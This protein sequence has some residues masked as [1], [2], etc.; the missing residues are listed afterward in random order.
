MRI[1]RL[2]SKLQLAISDAQSLAVGMDHPAIE[3]VHLLQALLEQQGGSIKPLLMQVGFD[4]NSLRQALVKE[5]DQLPKIQNPTGDVNMSQD[6]ARLLNQADRLAQQKGDQFISSELVL[7]AAMD[8][9]SKLGK[10]LLSQGVSKKA[11]ENA[12]NNLRGGA[13]VNDANAEE[14]RQALDK[15]TVDLTKR[16]EEGK[17][18]PVIGRDDEIRRTVQVLQRRTKNNPVLIGEPGVGKTAIAEGLAQRIINGEVPDG[19][20]GKRLLA[21]DMGA[22]IAGAKYRGEFEERLKGLLN[23]LSKQEGQIILFIDELHTMVGAGKG[24][25]AMDAGNMLKPALARGELHCVGA[26]TLNEYRQFI[27]KDAALER[28]FQKVLVEEPSEEDTI[29]ILRGLKERYEVHH[30]VAI[31]DGAIIAAAKLSHRYITDRQLP[32]KAID[33]ID[34][35]ASRIRMEI[36]SKPEVLDRLDR[37]LIQLKVESQALKKEEDEAAKKRLEKLTEEIDRLEREYADLEEIWASEKAEVQ[38]S[39]QI[40]QKIEQARQELETA[41]RKG[42]LSRMAELQYG[43]IPDLERSLQ[44][45]DQHGKTENQLLRNKVTE[46]EI[47]EVVS[48][49]TG[50]P[51]AKMLEGEREKLLKMEELLHQRVIGQNEA[52]TAVANAVRRSRAGLSDPNRPSGSFLFLGP[53]GVGK[54]ELCKALAEFLFDTEEAMVRIDMSEFMEKHS[55]ARLIGA[56]PGYV[57]YEEGGYLTE[58]VRRKPYS[59]VLLDEVEKAHP[60]VFNV[61]LQVLEDGRLTD[62][63]GRT[64]DF[65]NTVIVMTSNLG[66]AQIQELVGDREAQRAAVMDAVGSHFRPEFINRIDEVVVFEPLGREQIAGI[67]EIQLGRLRSRLLERELSLSLSPEALDKLIAVGYDPVYGA[68]PLKRAIQRWIENPLAQLILAGKFMPGTAI[69]AKVEGDEIVFG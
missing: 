41:R 20:K 63:H 19:L 28:R 6:L 1:D 56:P 44:M 67:T 46:E 22:L 69:T 65:R 61:L 15:Y 51:V 64:V 32:D 4:I 30:K 25:G 3:P 45:V 2:T 60:D 54:T 47:A 29:A 42:D 33:L 27:E 34:E 52:V 39:A 58:A 66:S 12:I 21:L 40:Q 5:L 16:A 50:I 62:S 14:S 68:R 59:V 35:A 7:L 8:E 53:T 18:D 13:A 49:W 23:E 17:L 48:K 55:V 31:T 43:V 26:T 38:G 57:G 37:R 11:L 10:L 36:D 9:N 24:E